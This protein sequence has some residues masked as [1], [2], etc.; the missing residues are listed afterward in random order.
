MTSVFN[1]RA[2]SNRHWDDADHLQQNKRVE[3]ADHLFG[4]SAECALKAVLSTLGEKLTSEGDLQAAAHQEHVDQLWSR[5]KFLAQG[6]PAAKYATLL[7]KN[8][9]TDWRVTQRYYDT[10]YVTPEKLQA[11]RGGAFQARKVLDQVILDNPPS[12][13]K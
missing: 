8:P 7:G 3:N 5:F 13:N 6:R 11:H 4:I 10:G 12:P 2:A 9:F 1:F